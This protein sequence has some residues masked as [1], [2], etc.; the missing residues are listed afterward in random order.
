MKYI[1]LSKA[2]FNTLKVGRHYRVILHYA[3][4][5]KHASIHRN[6]PF[7]IY[8]AQQYSKKLM[9]G[10]L[11]SMYKFGKFY[12]NPAM[13]PKDIT[14]FI[15][16]QLKKKSK[17]RRIIFLTCPSFPSPTLGHTIC[18]WTLAPKPPRT[19]FYYTMELAAIVPISLLMSQTVNLF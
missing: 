15:L 18:L 4:M 2:N 8:L 9:M 16:M 19:F 3:F 1:Y 17:F 13:F 5:I 14:T 7:L 6:T 11:K 10:Q 12:L